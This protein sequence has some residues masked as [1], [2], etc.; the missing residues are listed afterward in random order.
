MGGLIVIIIMTVVV[1][2]GFPCARQGSKHF[3]AINSLNPHKISV[4]R[5]YFY[6]HQLIL[7]CLEVEIPNVLS[8]G[9]HMV[10]PLESTC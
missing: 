10:G 3:T 6:P 5:K 1:I 8:Q 9:K 7:G 4:K 2:E